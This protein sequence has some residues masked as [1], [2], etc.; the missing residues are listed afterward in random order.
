MMTES[1][2]EGPDELSHWQTLRA[3]RA[4]RVRRVDF[5]C[6][7]DGPIGPEPVARKGEALYGIARFLG[8][9]SFFYSATPSFDIT[10]CLSE[11]IALNEQNKTIFS[12]V[13]RAE[14]FDGMD[15][16]KPSRWVRSSP[17]A[18][19]CAD[20][21]LPNSR[22]DLQSDPQLMYNLHL[23]SPLFTLRNAFSPELRAA[24]DARGFAIPL[25]QGFFSTAQV[26]HGGEEVLVTIIS[27]RRWARAGTRYNKRG[28]DGAGNVGNF[29][30]VSRL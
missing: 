18:E 9:G 12:P 8:D 30:E 26:E 16:A 11:R 15:A 1:S 10:L 3:E 29:A 22:S 23:L 4:Y 25:C 6:L 20:I 2:Y 19:L 7:N 14:A 13:A 27:R 17:K 28:I 21:S 24:F 5:Y